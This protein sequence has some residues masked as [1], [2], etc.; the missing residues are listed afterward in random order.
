MRLAFTILWFENQFSEVQ[1]AIQGLQLHLADSGFDLVIRKAVDGSGI[2]A[3]ARDQD[4][5]HEVDL[6]VVDLDLGWSSEEGDA[7]A[8]QV[9]QRFRFT[10]IVFYSGVAPTELRE[11]I[12]RRNVD[13]VYCMDRR[14]LR[15]NLIELVDNL[16]RRMSRLE[17]MRGLAV[18][19]AGKADARLRSI[20]LA[21]HGQADEAGKGEI[22]AFI[23]TEVHDTDNRIIGRY[24]RSADVQAKLYSLAC[25]S[26]VLLKAAKHFVGRQ[27]SLLAERKVLGQYQDEVM[28]VRNNLG[29]ATESRTRD[30]WV[31]SCHDG[32][33]ITR[34][35]FPAFRRSFSRHLS[36]LAAICHRLGVE[37]D[38][39][40][41]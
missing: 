37:V 22:A 32:R 17:S 4:L 27:P 11:R 33:R 1:P 28:A 16:I 15:L 38:G 25:T 13:G 26:M 41:E 24:D 14:D 7:I 9:R 36:N 29:H 30:G 34:D 20:L 3:F 10:D 23:D 2:D 39:E 19:T 21:L 31:I 5:F 8:E 40:P 35:D 12:Q 6:I 18:A